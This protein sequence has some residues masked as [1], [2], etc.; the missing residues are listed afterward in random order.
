MNDRRH[1]YP[2]SFPKDDP[3]PSV[4]LAWAIL[5]HYKPGTIPNIVRFELAGS[6]AGAHSEMDLLKDA[7]MAVLA[8]SDFVDTIPFERMKDL[9]DAIPGFGEKMVTMQLALARLRPKN[10]GT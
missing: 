2:V 6:I 10:G 4:Q 1:A 9:S 5:D 8:F 7:L 3:R